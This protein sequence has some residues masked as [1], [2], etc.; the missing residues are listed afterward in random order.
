[1]GH[2]HKAALADRADPFSAGVPFST[3]VLRVDLASASV[4]RVGLLERPAPGVRCTRLVPS[5][6]EHPERLERVPAS[7][8]APAWAHALVLASVPG[9]AE[10]LEG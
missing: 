4:R 7:A 10:V 9:W 2:L 8:S 3:A 6:A 1:M 5:L